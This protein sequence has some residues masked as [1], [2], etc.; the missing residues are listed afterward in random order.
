MSDATESSKTLGV[1]VLGRGVVGS[2]VLDILGRRGDLLAARTGTRFDVRH[3][4]VRDPGKHA[5]RRV[6]TDADAAIADPN[7]GVVVELIGGLDTARRLV[8]AALEH[9]KHVVTANKSL[10]A[11][12]G[13]ELFRLARANDVCLAFEASCG[14]GMPIVS[15]LLGGLVANRV[16]ALVGIL[17]GTCNFILTKMSAEGAT[18]AEALAEAQ[19]AGF[20]EADPTLDVSGR[21]AAQ[22]LAILASLSFDQQLREDD[23]SVEGI[24]ALQAA[25]VALAG[26][27]GYVVKLLAVAERH[28]DGQLAC[29]VAPHLVPAGDVMAGVA[30]PF[31]AVSVYGD[32]L[33]HALF[34]GRGA[35]QMP[36]ASAVVADLLAVATGAAPAQFRALRAFGGDLPR[37]DILPAGRGTSRSYLRVTARDVPGVMAEICRALGGH[38][39]SIAAVRQHESDEG[40]MV[41]IVITT[42]DAEEGA[43]AAAVRE[44]DALPDVGAATV[45]LRLLDAP[46]EPGPAA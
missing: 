20:A 14:G 45:R 11:A 18:Y 1:T 42:H 29:R 40:Q 41:P 2:G 28:G 36:T 44:I 25:D 4:V 9:G 13:P 8:T 17:N 32:A 15:A 30:G 24:D 3:V 35:G 39:I 38:G 6:T 31:N 12:H 10:L 19:A 34:Y 23:V 22:K 7:V 21:D 16:D 46:A 27:M 43:T 37:A 33:G 26:E 5:D